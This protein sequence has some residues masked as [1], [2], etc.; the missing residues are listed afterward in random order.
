M[1]TSLTEERL[2][3]WLAQVQEATGREPVDKL[4]EEISWKPY[5]LRCDTMGRMTR[6]PYGFICE[7]VGDY[8]SRVGCRNTIGIDM[9]HY[10]VVTP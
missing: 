3:V 4:L 2:K 10:E 1:T 5:C 7:G 8:F 9:T 6:T